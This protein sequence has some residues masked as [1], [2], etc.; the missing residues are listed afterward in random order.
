M[1]PSDALYQI[2]AKGNYIL[3]PLCKFTGAEHSFNPVDELFGHKICKSSHSHHSAVPLTGD[4]LQTL[5]FLKLLKHVSNTNGTHVNTGITVHMH[6]KRK[7]P[8]LRL[9]VFVPSSCTRSQN[10][11]PHIL[12]Q[13][14]KEGVVI[15]WVETPVGDDDNSDVCFGP[16][17]V[18]DH[19]VVGV[20]KSRWSPRPPRDPL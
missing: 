19:V 7:T 14:G 3:F 11:A 17:A 4:A 16:A 13:V 8:A 12:A 20:F 9:V 1:S 10:T 6:R 15:S 2:I 18:P 5:T